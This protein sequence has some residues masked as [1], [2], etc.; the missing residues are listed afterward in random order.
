[1]R[2]GACT[3]GASIKGPDSG[4]RNPKPQ[5]LRKYM[6]SRINIAANKKAKN[7]AVLVL[8]LIVMII[9]FVIVTQYSYTT[10]IEYLLAENSE[11][12]LDAYYSAR[13][14]VEAAKAFLAEDDTPLY[15]AETDMWG[16]KYEHRSNILAY[17]SMIGGMS[18]AFTIRDT[19]RG[20]NL[21]GL[22][23]N[24]KNIQKDTLKLIE[25]FA[26]AV[27]AESIG[28]DNLHLRIQDFLDND[29]S[30]DY[31]SDENLNKNLVVLEEILEMPDIGV[32]EMD[33]LFFGY[34]EDLAGTWGGEPERVRGLK[35]CTTI[36]GDNTSSPPRININTAPREV[37]VAVIL[38]NNSE[39]EVSAAEEEADIIIEKRDEIN[40]EAEEGADEKTYFKNFGSIKKDLEAIECSHAAASSRWFTIKAGPVGKPEFFIVSYFTTGGTLQK[41]IR[42]VIERTWSKRKEAS[43]TMHMWREVPPR[44]P[45][46]QDDIWD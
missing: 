16:E 33:K 38:M 3:G 36:W 11:E 28:V 30:G 25:N 24:N 5:A 26:K 8:A 31:D 46:K 9:I 27:D 29:T 23:S 1:V 37:L 4:L 14:V 18:G 42:I 6:H 43:F 19:A 39:L 32:E 22:W 35:E 40:T 13:S 20:I 2:L 44:V 34:I 10:K 41:E 15:D 21:A 12:N 17:A 45:P 7:G